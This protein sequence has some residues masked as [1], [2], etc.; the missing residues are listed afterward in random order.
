[1]DE[2]TDTLDG[3]TDVV[4]G[5]K[6][7]NVDLS[8]IFYAPQWFL[9]GSDMNAIGLPVW[10]SSDWDLQPVDFQISPIRK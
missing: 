1:M 8:L 6:A 10:T 4:I 9:C 5:H 2:S 3:A 7:A